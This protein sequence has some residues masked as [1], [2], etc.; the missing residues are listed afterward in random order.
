MI[1]V[2]GNI[3]VGHLFY[4]L[5]FCFEYQVFVLAVH[6]VVHATQIWLHG[7][8]PVPSQ[9]FARFQLLNRCLE[10]CKS[11]FLGLVV[12]IIMAHQ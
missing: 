7:S 8:M 5:G 6:V 4:L 2:I 3:N 10:A 12:H 11:V 9:L 1:Y